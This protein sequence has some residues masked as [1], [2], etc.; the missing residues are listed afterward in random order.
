MTECPICYETL[1][2]LQNL[3][4]KHSFCENCLKRLKVRKCPFCR[5]RIR[6]KLRKN[7]YNLR[8]QKIR[9]F[10]P[11]KLVVKFRDG[12]VRS[13]GQVIIGERCVEQNFL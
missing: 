3:E 7:P 13:K 10:E 8:T 9:T 1:K 2:Q 11:K 12:N 6:T 5:K 4:C